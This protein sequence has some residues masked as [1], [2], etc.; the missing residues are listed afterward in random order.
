[1]KWSVLPQQILTWLGMYLVVAFSSCL[2]VAA[3]EVLTPWHPPLARDAGRAAGSLF[4]ST[5]PGDGWLNGFQHVGIM[6]NLIS[7]A[8]ISG[9]DAVEGFSL[10][11]FCLYRSLQCRAQ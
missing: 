4:F 5:A 3:I 10:C 8:D 11:W 7:G 9:T 6:G 2:D 1:M